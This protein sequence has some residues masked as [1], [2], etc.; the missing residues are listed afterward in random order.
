[1]NGS[2]SMRRFDMLLRCAGGVKTVLPC[3]WG[4][5]DVPRGFRWAANAVGS[6]ANLRGIRTNNKAYERMC[7]RKHACALCVE[8]RTNKNPNISRAAAD[9]KSCE[10]RTTGT[11]RL[12]LAVVAVVDFQGSAVQKN[13]SRI[14]RVNLQRIMRTVSVSIRIFHCICCVINFYEYLGA[15]QLN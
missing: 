12:A 9:W 6:C 14:N 3:G 10:T 8:F 11:K 13:G 2:I 7:N 4:C 5:L 15:Y 1:M